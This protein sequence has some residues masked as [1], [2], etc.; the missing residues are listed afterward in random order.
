MDHR[1]TRYGALLCALVTAFLLYPLGAADARAGTALRVVP[2][3]VGSGGATVTVDGECPGEPVIGLVASDEVFY[4]SKLEISLVR[5]VD[6][7]RFASEEFTVGNGGTFRDD[8]P[9][10]AELP[11]GEYAFVVGLL[12]PEAD[13]LFWDG[14]TC[15]TSADL[16]IGSVLKLSAPSVVA[17][18]EVRATGTCPVTTG[19]VTVLLA[20]QQ[21]RS[22][23]VDPVTGTFGPLSFS[24]PAGAKAGPAQIDS[25]CG[26]H[27]PLLIEEAPVTS[28]PPSS[29]PPTSDP[30]TSPSVTSSSPGTA[31]PQVTSASPTG[32]T[33]EVVEVPR[34]I[35]LSED[36]ARA[37][38][39]KDLLLNPSGEGDT[40]ES[41]SPRAGS[42]VPRGSTV[43]VTLGGSGPVIPKS[44]TAVVPA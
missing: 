10:P 38:L 34:L 42:L 20:E 8:F 17:G 13:D 11:D 6:G 22:G 36:E 37:K 29:D 5:K 19:S 2:P 32:P 33:D 26:G 4:P 3:A 30:A 27:A 39:G 25:S 9:L 7:E 15:D 24:V 14:W 16:A 1:S 18:G 21:L 43:D 12:P 23:P 40:V 28:Q 44:I 31:G 41:Q 35:D